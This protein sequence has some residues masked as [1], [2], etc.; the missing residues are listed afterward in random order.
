MRAAWTVL[1]EKPW[2]RTS[3]STRTKTRKLHCHVST[4]AILLDEENIVKSRRYRPLDLSFT[5]I[6][7]QYFLRSLLTVARYDNQISQKNT[8]LVFPDM[9]N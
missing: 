9:P 1:G 2:I 3:A 7:W 6:R 4:T 5:P 8:R